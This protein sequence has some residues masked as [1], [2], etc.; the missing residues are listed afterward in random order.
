LKI[1]DTVGAAL[2]HVNIAEILTDRGEWGE[3][4]TLLLG[5]LPL[6]KASQYRY[7]MGLCLW[8]LGRTTLRLGRVDAALGHLEEAKS[9]FQQVGAEEQVPLVDARIAECRVEMGNADAALE[10]VRGMLGRASES[11]GV[12]KVA[13][14]L[15]RIQ[16]HALL[17]QDDLWGARDALESSL[18]AAR[19]RKD[20]FEV[21]LTTLSLIELDRREGVEPPL[22]MVDESRSLLASLKVRAVPPVPVAAH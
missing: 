20:L 13:S 1:G 22:D 21:A 9:N 19:E 16:A 14:L 5:T 18:A 3:A 10:L 15:E 17:L 4:E 2:A 7:Y 6:W 8:Y 12:A 11:N